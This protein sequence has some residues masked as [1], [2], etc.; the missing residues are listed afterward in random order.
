MQ[1]GSV[2]QRIE[3]LKTLINYHRHLYHVEDRQEISEEALDSLKHELYLLEQKYP[4]YI[5]P[6]SPTQRV[7][8]E[9]LEKFEK[10]EHKK[11]MVSLEDCFSVE[12]LFDWQKYLKKLTDKKFNYFCELK[13]DGFAISLI[14]KKGI[15]DKAVTR[16]DGKIGEDVTANIK[17]IQSVPLNIKED[18]EIRGEVYM[19]KKDFN[20]INKQRE[21]PYSNPR[22]LAAGTIRQLDSKVTASRNLKFLA[23]DLIS[24]IETHEEKHRKLK[25]LGFRTDKGKICNSL[26][27]VDKYLQWVEDQ[28]DKLEYLID[29]AVI[30]INQT[31]VFEEL[32]IVGKTPRGARAFKFQAEQATTI[33]EDI[34]FQVGRTGTITPVAVL[35]PVKIGGVTVKRATLHNEDQIKRLGLKIGDTVIIERAGD[36]IPAV[37]KVFK[38][39]RSGKEKDFKMP[40][41]CPVC[42]SKLAK[43]QGEVA[44]RCVS[45]NCSA[46]KRESLDHFV[47]RKSFNIDGLGQEIIDQLV[48]ADLVH[49]FADIF[50]LKR[51]DL[52][53]LERFADKSVDNLL[54][55]IEISKD[56]KLN[57]FINSLGIRHVGENT[58]V[59]LANHFKTIDNFLITTQDELL[60]LRDIGPK[61]AET[62]IGWIKENKNLV[63]EL[64]SLGV[65]ITY[66]DSAGKLSGM[67]FVLTGTLSIGRDE[68]KE[69]IRRA[70]GDVSSTVGKNT[71]VI[72]GESPG[73]KFDKAKQKGSRIIDEKEFLKLVS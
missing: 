69:M 21:I 16:G 24:D 11:R 42:N 1:D 38:E 39:L 13:I 57:K 49:N 6:D 2:K 43:K 28:R 59:D 56:I 46:K 58:S 37:V 52:I 64:I 66:D 54:N 33:V 61:A 50:K 7:A 20:K 15:L 48:E 27:E 44:W 68:A 71:I 40:A 29:G 60:S 8:G 63:K 9:P 70:G 62:I 18:L 31:D 22:N 12:E 51:K 10:Y 30:N 32:G 14:Y 36:V 55:A 26:E 4:E 23:Y 3:K 35:K 17:T 67:S 73:S 25:E 19:D 45:N 65:N 47:S 53:G 41:Q 72:A 34:K 5:T